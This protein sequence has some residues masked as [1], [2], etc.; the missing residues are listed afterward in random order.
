MP[1]LSSSPRVPPPVVFLVPIS[2]V[3]RR[4]AGGGEGGAAGRSVWAAAGDALQLS[5]DDDDDKGFEPAPK[6]RKKVLSS[7]EVEAKSRADFDALLK[8]LD[9]DDDGGGSGSYRV[10]RTPKKDE[11]YT[12]Q[13]E[14]AATRERAGV[15]RGEG[16]K[17]GQLEGEELVPFI[18]ETEV[19]RGR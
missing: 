4:N 1:P 16:G 8:G 5:S 17:G 12:R 11:A 13:D 15:R 6:R 9:S 19:A 7:A 10:K 14:R 18:V 3:D 2:R